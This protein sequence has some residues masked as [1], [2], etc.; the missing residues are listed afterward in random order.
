MKK[1]KR[2][3]QEIHDPDALMVYGSEPAL[4]AFWRVEVVFPCSVMV[5]TASIK[6]D[7]LRL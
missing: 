6:L 3:R 2:M 4:Q 1:K 5:C 7:P